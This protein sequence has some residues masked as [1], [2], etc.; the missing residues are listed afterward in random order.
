LEGDTFLVGILIDNDITQ[1][2]LINS[3]KLEEFKR[4][5]AD[6]LSVINKKDLYAYNSDME[7]GSFKKLLGES[8]NIFDMKPFSGRGAT[9]EYFFSVLVKEKVIKADSIGFSDPL[10]G[11]SKK[12]PD[13]WNRKLY[14]EVRDH[15]RCCLTKEA[16]I[17]EHN[18][19]LKKRF[20][21][22]VNNGWLKD[23]AVLPEID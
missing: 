4:A 23:D 5:I 1:I 3:S 19:Y 20:S 13:Y 11:D 17:L 6:E 2:M 15:N 9:K 8:P 18:D 16:K 10:N 12:C 22:L 21:S 7:M 14:D